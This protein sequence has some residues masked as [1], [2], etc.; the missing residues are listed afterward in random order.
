MTGRAVLLKWYQPTFICISCMIESPAGH[1][2]P[3]FPAA[4][5]SKSGAAF[6]LIELLVVIAI[7]AILAAMLLPVL[8]KAKIRA[9]GMQCL[10]DQK[11]LALAWQLYATDFGDACA[12][13][14][15]Q[16]EQ[17]WLVTNPSNENWLSGWLGADGSGGD[18]T[19]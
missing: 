6:T 1:R 11:Q 14:K 3:H 15:W 10:N 8:S 12:G 9:Q 7:I 5:I 13:N 18:G 19:G 16:D 4:R 17:T 2:L